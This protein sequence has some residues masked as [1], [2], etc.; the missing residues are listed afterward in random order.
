MF[1]VDAKERKIIITDEISRRVTEIK[2]GES[3]DRKFLEG[4][5][6]KY[7]CVLKLVEVEIVD[8]KTQEK[9]GK[10]ELRAFGQ[11]VGNPH[12]LMEFV[13]E[14]YNIA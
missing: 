8:P 1:V 2:E 12:W 6:D 11:R 3:L 10:K 5:Q 4:T 14:E 7:D 13:E 9:T